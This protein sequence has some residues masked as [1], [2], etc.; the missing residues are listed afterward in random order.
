MSTGK[1]IQLY[2]D[3]RN[4]QLMKLLDDYGERSGI[5]RSQL[6]GLAIQEYLENRR[7]LKPDNPFQ[8]CELRRSTD[9]EVKVYEFLGTLLE[10][11]M[12][13]SMD[14]FNLWR[15]FITGQG[16]Y[17]ISIESRTKGITPGKKVLFSGGLKT[18][19]IG[20]EIVHDFAVFSAEV[21]S[22]KPPEALAG[23][24]VPKNFIQK[25]QQVCAEREV[26]WLDI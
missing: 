15:V 17:V 10:Q 11:S 12:E 23:Y 14:R 19:S 25:A 8:K 3:D 16:Q 1:T 13:S 24:R 2:L 21:L 22:H 20:N 4:R 26:E 7:I 6:V 5:A 9:G 18:V